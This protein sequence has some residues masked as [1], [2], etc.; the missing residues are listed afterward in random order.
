MWKQQMNAVK[1]ILIGEKQQFDYIICFNKESVHLS[2]TKKRDFYL[3]ILRQN[4]NKFSDRSSKWQSMIC[5]EFTDF[6]SCY[7]PP[8]VM[9]DGDLSWRMM[10]GVVATGSLLFRMNVVPNELCPFCSNY[11]DL[12]HIFYGCPRLKSLFRFLC[13]LLVHFFPDIELHFKEWWLFGVPSLY[14]PSINV[15]KFRIVNWL[16]VLARKSIYESRS[17]KING[18]LPDGVLFIFKSKMKYR[19]A[20]EIQYAKHT[21]ELNKFIKL[22]CLS[23]LNCYIVDDKLSYGW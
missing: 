10:H 13:L 2:D 6:K 16:I 22:W 3:G 17:N 11:D 1:K 23:L 18:D 14:G 8:S 5:D 9:R 19:L 15:R 12:M 4:E 20:V 7:A 21:E